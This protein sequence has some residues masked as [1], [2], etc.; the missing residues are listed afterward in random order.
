M[1]AFLIRRRDKEGVT[2]LQNLK[3]SGRRVGHGKSR[4][5][6]GKHD[7]L[8]VFSECDPRPLLLEFGY[9][10]DAWNFGG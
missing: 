1:R 2:G 6:G 9:L 5:E 8:D 10:F 7:G 4:E 3:E